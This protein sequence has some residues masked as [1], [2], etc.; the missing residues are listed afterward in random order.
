MPFAAEIA[1]D[2]ADGAAQTVTL[3]D[4]S[5]IVL[6]KVAADYDPS[7]PGVALD[8]I[9]QRMRRGE[10]LTGLLHIARDAA[11][12]HALGATPDTP[13]NAIPYES[14]SPGGDALRRVLDAFR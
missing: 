13:L 4:G 10:Y 3:H 5:R 9:Q 7:D 2:Y 11:D 12:I 8:A 1:V 14:L 6:R